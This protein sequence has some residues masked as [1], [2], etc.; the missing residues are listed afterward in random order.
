MAT[1]VL[2]PTSTASSGGNRSWETPSNIHDTSPSTAKVV[3]NRSN[4]VA[5]TLRGGFA[6][7]KI[8]KDATITGLEVTV[9]RSQSGD[10][11][12]VD[13]TAA[14]LVNGVSVG[15][16]KAKPDR[17]PST[18]QTSTYGG[19]DDLWGL[20]VGQLF[21]ADNTFKAFQFGYGPEVTSGKSDSVEL[22]IQY[23]KATVYYSKGGFRFKQSGVFKPVQTH[24][25]VNGSWVPSG[26]HFVFKNGAWVQISYS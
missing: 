2:L 1:K 13:K 17:W 16:D 26:D 15:Q 19:E 20:Q 14:L 18:L 3:L 10:Y 6:S 8:D 23:M 24:I 7:F 22:H 25:R 5:D 11:D 21:D 4:Q 9:S 12:I